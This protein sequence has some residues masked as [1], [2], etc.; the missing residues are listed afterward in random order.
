MKRSKFMMGSPRSKLVYCNTKPHIFLNYRGD[1]TCYWGP[2]TG[3]GFNIKADEY[4]ERR[5]GYK[6]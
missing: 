2:I 3:K 5:N 1:Y 4:C 6:N